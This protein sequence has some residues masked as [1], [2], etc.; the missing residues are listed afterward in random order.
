MRENIQHLLNRDYRSEV[1]D[2]LRENG[3]VFSTDGLTIRLADEF[4]FC[5]GVDRAVDYAFRPAR[6][7]PTSASTSRG[8]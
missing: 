5:Y 4:G 6:S 7:S 2:R 1:V 8:T 3:N